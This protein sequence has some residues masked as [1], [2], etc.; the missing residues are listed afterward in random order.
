M[1][2]SDRAVS[3]TFGGDVRPAGPP[4]HR[5]SA[6]D[7]WNERRWDRDSPAD[8]GFVTFAG[9]MREGTI[10][11]THSARPGNVHIDLQYA[12]PSHEYRLVTADVREGWLRNVAMTAPGAWSYDRIVD[13]LLEVAALPN[14]R[15]VR[16]EGQRLSA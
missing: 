16:V 6:F 10:L 14:Q 7:G 4:P 1:D 5:L 8:R 13:A 9:H 12:D 15:T 11:V 3:D 2:R